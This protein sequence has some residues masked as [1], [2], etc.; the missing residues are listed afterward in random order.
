[1]LCKAKLWNLINYVQNLKIQIIDVWVELTRC[2]NESLGS[3]K[4]FWW[5]SQINTKITIEISL[6]HYY[7]RSCKPKGFLRIWLG[8]RVTQAINYVGDLIVLKCK[9][10]MILVRQDV[11]QLRI[12]S[13]TWRTVGIQGLMKFKLRNKATT[14]CMKYL[15]LDCDNFM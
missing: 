14:F 9:F 3:Q 11:C 6:K 15:R 5:K 7:Q 4:G 10:K 2:C 12:I 13:Y 8:A 1:M